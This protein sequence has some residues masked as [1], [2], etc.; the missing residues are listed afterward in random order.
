MA[1]TFSLSIIPPSHAAWSGCASRLRPI[2]TMRWSTRW[3]RPSSMYGNGLDCRCDRGRLRPSS[4]A[5]ANTSVQKR[6]PLEQRLGLALDLERTRRSPRHER[7]RQRY[8]EN[9]REMMRSDVDWVEVERESQQ[10]HCV[11][12]AGRKR[13]HDFGNAQRQYADQHSCEH[14]RYR[15]GGRERTECG[16]EEIQQQPWRRV[17]EG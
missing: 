5:I 8:K 7:H 1:S 13:D 6:G 10:H 2:T 16:A 3:P 17:G 11:D 12:G 9:A 15:N 4:H 14:R